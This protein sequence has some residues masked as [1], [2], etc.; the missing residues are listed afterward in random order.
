MGGSTAVT[1]VVA[2][3]A[4]VLA[5]LFLREIGAPLYGAWLATGELLVWLQAFDLGLPNLLIQRIG[6]AHARKD[7]ATVGEYL[8]T[9]LLAL[10]LIALA[11][12]AAVIAMAAWV[13][14]FIGIVG[15]EASTLSGSLIVAGV[16]TAVAI[17]TSAVLGFSR[18]IQQTGW[19]SAVLVISA[20]AGFVV[21]LTL[22][23]TGA[24]LWAAAFGIASRCGILVLGAAIF[25][26]AHLRRGLSGHFRLRRAVWNEVLSLSPVTA[27]GGLAYAG[28]NQ[29]EAAIVAAFGTPQL[30]AAYTLTRRAAD[31]ARVL[32]DMLGAATYGSFAHLVASSERH[33]ALSVFRE[34][35]DLR[36][37]L[38]IAAAGAYL[39]VNGSLVGAW[40][41]SSM[42]LGIWMTLAFA[43]QMLVVGQGY[44]LNYLYRA[45]GAVGPGSW[46]LLGEALLRIPLMIVL[47]L[48]LGVVGLPVAGIITAAAFGAWAWSRARHAL[49]IDFAGAL[50]ASQRLLA[51]RL[52]VIGLGCAIGWTFQQPSWSWTLGMGVVFTVVS[53]SLLAAVDRA[54]AIALAGIRAELRPLVPFL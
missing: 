50:P 30:A 7:P 1:V 10:A 54:V 44:L 41:G 27:L 31:L 14:P 32:I 36:L 26:G 20:L 21:T 4:L 15:P 46:M 42:Y 51:V 38:A 18:G 43:L 29:S 17:P 9:G 52:A 12:A 5:P 48:A 22:L 25:V 53:V 33:R 24:G 34:I 39:S 28:M 19:M 47:F 37:S 49:G 45:T 11:A 8:T 2:V 23:L 3:Q 16:A 35:T 13:P 40:V 6:A